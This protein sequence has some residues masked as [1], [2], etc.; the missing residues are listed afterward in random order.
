MFC[1]YN[2]DSYECYNEAGNRLYSGLTLGQ[3]LGVIFGYLA[4]FYLLARHYYRS[5]EAR[6]L[7]AMKMEKMECDLARLESIHVIL[8]A[9]PQLL[10][11]RLHDSNRLTQ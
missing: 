1:N 9:M 11:Q 10:E 2:G 4:L 5:S 7:M 8:E 3:L 6:K